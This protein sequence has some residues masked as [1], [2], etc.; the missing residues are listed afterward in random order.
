MKMLDHC[1]GQWA[2]RE[3][4]R[5]EAVG[6][7]DIRQ[8]Y[9]NRARMLAHAH[10]QA[11]AYLNNALYNVDRLFNGQRLDTK[12]RRFIEKCL[13]VAQVDND[14]IRKL[15][16]R[17]GVMLDELLKPSLNPQHSS[18]YIVGSGRQPDH[19]NQAFTVRRERGG[20]IYLTERFF[21]PGLEVYLPIRPRTFDAYGHHMATVL[22]HEI[23][24]MTLQTLDF[25]YLDPSRPFVDLIDTSTPDGRLRHLVLEELQ[26]NALSATT[27]GN[28]LF[29]TLDDYELRWNDVEGDLRQRALSLTG[30]RDLDSARRVFYS[31]AGK[32]TDVILNNADSLALLI[33][34]LGRPVEFQP[35]EE[36]RSNPST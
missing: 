2:I 3:E 12:R 32:R 11:V 15:K 28:E 13:G 36:P 6:I 27:P 16:I 34:H 26:Q 29:K 18:R 33:T 10:R 20:N 4:L 22:L 7:H 21:E 19:G 24:H 9:P 5:V 1:I 35:L 23:S 31:D 17:M 14:I 30:T 25:A 8:L